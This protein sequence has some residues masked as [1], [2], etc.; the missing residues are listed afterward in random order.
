[1]GRLYLLLYLS[2]RSDH[3][4]QVLRGRV[5]D[6]VSRV[7][8]LDPWIDGLLYRHASGGRGNGGIGSLEENW[9]RGDGPDN[10][11]FLLA[12]CHARK[13]G[14]RDQFVREIR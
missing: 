7:D 11:L 6:R 10:G 5:A 13:W 8:P 2:V 9:R 3:A 4:D 1:M 12:L 14:T